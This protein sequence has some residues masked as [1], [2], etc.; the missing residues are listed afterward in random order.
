MCTK[1]EN[2]ISV[3]DSHPGTL[4][5]LPSHGYLCGMAKTVSKIALIQ[6]ER[7]RLETEVSEMKE[8]LAVKKFRLQAPQHCRRSLRKPSRRGGEFEARTARGNAQADVVGKAF[9]EAGRYADNA[10][11]DI[12][13][14]ARRSDTRPKGTRAERHRAL[15]RWSLVAGRNHQF[16]RTYCLENV[17][18]RPSDK[19]WFQV[20][21]PKNDEGPNESTSEPSSSERGAG[22]GPR[23][24]ASHPS[25][26][27]STPVSSTATLRRDLFASTSVSSGHIPLSRKEAVCVASSHSVMSC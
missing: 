16:G 22:G 13:G 19:T 26:A 18:A 5:Q 6:Q 24:A 3:V 23:G 2:H 20:F 7:R 12:R 11:Y 14:F 17:Q 8:T 25:P 10:R 9:A 27:G 15:H 1:G 4:A 21:L